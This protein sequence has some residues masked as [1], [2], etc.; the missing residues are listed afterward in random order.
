MDIGTKIEIFTDNII[1]AAEIA[2]PVIACGNRQIIYPLEIRNLVRQKC[3]V[4]KTWHSTRHPPDKNE[5]NRVSKK[6]YYYTLL[7]D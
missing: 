7:I 1:N 4:R 5:W 3:R 2:T 6:H